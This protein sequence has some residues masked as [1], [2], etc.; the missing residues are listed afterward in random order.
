MCYGSLVFDLF[1]CWF[2]IIRIFVSFWCL[3][4]ADTLFWLVFGGVWLLCFEFVFWLLWV[5]V[6]E[7]FASLVWLFG[8]LFWFGFVLIG[9]LWWFSFG[10]CPF[11][12]VWRLW[13]TLLLMFAIYFGFC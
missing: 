7:V 11:F 3:P 2:V 4:C 13:I 5:W 10:I 8:G 12:T 1:L 6:L 9:V